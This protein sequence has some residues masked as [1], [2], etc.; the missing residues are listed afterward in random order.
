MVL[1][2]RKPI[3]YVDTP[4][5]DDPQTPVWLIPQTREFFLTYDSYLER[6]D[7]YKRRQ[8]ICEITGNLYLTY[9]EAKELE[10]REIEALER[11]FP[12]ALREHILRFL[13]FNRI[14]RLDL[15]IDRVY[16]EFKHE[17]FPGEMV[18]L[19]TK[20]SSTALD[21]KRRAVVLEKVQIGGDVPVTRYLVRRLQDNVPTQ[22][23]SENILRDRN[24]FTKWLIKT[25]IK[26]TVSR[27]SRVGAPW[28]VK[29]FYAKKYRIPQTYPED[30]LQY[31]DDY[32]DP[33]AV[34]KKLLKK[35]KDPVE[36][37]QVQVTSRK[38]PKPAI[39]E[40]LIE[41]LALD[42]MAVPR[43]RG[44]RYDLFSID[45][46]ESLRIWSFINIFHRA[47]HLDAITFDDFLIALRWN[48]EQFKE[49]GN[50]E[51]LDELFCAMLGAIILNEDRKNKG[52]MVTI[53]EV[54]KPEDEAASGDE[55]GD[56]HGEDHGDDETEPNGVENGSKKSKPKL[57]G[58]TTVAD[59]DDEEDDHGED[60]DGDDSIEIEREVV[61]IHSGSSEEEEEDEEEEG[62][63]DDEEE[64]EDVTEVMR[65][66]SRKRGRTTSVSPR[67]GGARVVPSTSATPTPA[68]G[69]NTNNDDDDDEDETDHYA[70]KVMNHR[71]QWFDRIHRRQFRDGLWQCGVIG[72][73]SEVKDV[74][75]YADLCSEVFHKLAPKSEGVPTPNKVLERWYRDVD[76]GLRVRILSLMVDLLCTGQVV[77]A[78]LE[79]CSEEGTVLRRQRI[80]NIREY[81]ALVEQA[82]RLWDQTTTKVARPD[83]FGMFSTTL[84]DEERQL[85]DTDK[86]YAE[87]LQQRTDTF[88]KIRQL[89][90]VKR[91]LEKRILELD[92][93][94]AE[95]LGKDRF[96]NRYW[97]FENSA[98]T[99]DHEENDDKDDVAQD[100]DLLE[101]TYLMGTLW[102]QGP[103]N[104]DVQN[105]GQRLAQIKG[106]SHDGDLID[107]THWEYYDE[108]QDIDALLQWLNIRGIREHQLHKELALNAEQLR[109]AMTA[110]KVALTGPYDKF[111]DQLLRVEQTLRE[112]NNTEGPI[113]IDDDDDDDEDDEAVNNGRRQSRRRV[114]NT[115][116]DVDASDTN[117]DNDNDNDDDSNDDSDEEIDIDHAITSKNRAELLEAQLYLEERLAENPE[118]ARVMEWVN[119]DAVDNLGKLLY[120]GGDKF[121]KKRKK[122]PAKKTTK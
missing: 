69:T 75:Q 86:E 68:P 8:F 84:T 96:Y 81:K 28:V 13:Q 40:P 114:A 109:A 89:R 43:P 3:E 2:R 94:R 10:A 35:S 71:S 102:V 106:E 91:S 19:K 15:L 119:S 7:F 34:K 46:S 27:S 77:R 11:N 79:Y 56:D 17:Y 59:D 9:F 24:Q 74:P 101:E 4:L 80:E 111:R 30:L 116:I 65:P 20:L 121:V 21:N 110:R 87:L 64:E 120:D 12:D 100:D 117:N 6:L 60:D 92:C 61:D 48:L 37:V 31:A 52:L 1:F 16:L 54:A 49:Y 82:S 32:H 85:A 18:Y 38:L 73:L 42:P 98:I 62:E 22:V 118:V 58:T 115:P 41:D 57:N 50:C 47:L 33:A 51:L 5:P 36:Q 66:N 26:L 105:H 107:G 63:D 97:W 122:K 99:A 23:T 113:E 45:L 29:D 70:F 83:R 76:P 53:P 14:T 93:Q 78:R 95:I 103:S 25:F 104:G 67:K 90:A 44:K 39:D 108:P 55:N 72:V 88:T 112:L